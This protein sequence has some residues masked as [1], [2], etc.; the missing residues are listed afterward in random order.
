MGRG[1][2]GRNGN[3]GVKEWKDSRIVQMF[4]HSSYTWMI[5]L[6]FYYII[7]KQIKQDMFCMMVFIPFMELRLEDKA[8]IC[9]EN[10]RMLI[11]AV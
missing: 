8:G 11:S 4:K 2:E 7:I 5:L 10:M 6:R 3:S 1:D 9:C